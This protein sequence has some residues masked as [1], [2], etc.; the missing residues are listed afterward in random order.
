MSETEICPHKDRRTTTNWFTDDDDDDDDDEGV[1]F[2]SRCGTPPVG[3]VRLGVLWSSLRSLRLS[4]KHLQSPA[5]EDAGSP[6][7]PHRTLQM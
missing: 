5:E 7:R 1:Y 2:L 4:D 6:P 3:G